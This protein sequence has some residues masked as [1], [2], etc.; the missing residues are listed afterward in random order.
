MQ[1]FHTNLARCLFKIIFNMRFSSIGI[2]Y[3]VEEDLDDMAYNMVTIW[4]NIDQKDPM[5][6][7]LH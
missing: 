3:G 6:T 4:N 7:T 1:S 2:Q 5:Y